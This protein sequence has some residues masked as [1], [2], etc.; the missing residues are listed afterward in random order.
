MQEKSTGSK[1]TGVGIGSALKA[2]SCGDH[3]RAS[4]F[5][6]LESP[7]HART[8]TDTHTNTC[9]ILRPHWSAFD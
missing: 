3:E 1:L 6:V 8:P 4:T 2:V 7:T 9:P 5:G